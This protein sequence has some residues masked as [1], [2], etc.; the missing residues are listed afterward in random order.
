MLRDSNG[1]LSEIDVVAGWPFKVYIECK[2]YSGPVPL[3]MVSK[4]KVCM[5]VF[6]Y[7]C[8]FALR[9]HC[10]AFGKS[11]LEL[12]NIPLRRGLFVTTSTYTPRARTIGIRTM[13]GKEL[14]ARERLFRR[15]GTANRLL[16]VLALGVVGVSI[17]REFE[18]VPRRDNTA[19]DALR[20]ARIAALNIYKSQETHWRRIRQ[21]LNDIFGR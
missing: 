8:H 21:R 2:N 4:F 13:D 15:L 11:V 7:V 6:V 16:L 17:W 9:T 19:D 3:E 10:V 1:N 5:C 18:S 14:D 20:R 12:N